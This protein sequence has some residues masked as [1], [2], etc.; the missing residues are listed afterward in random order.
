MV[1]RVGGVWGVARPVRES[2]LRAMPAAIPEPY[3]SRLAR[4]RARLA[5]RRLDG[6][7]ITDRN[8]QIWATG[9]TGEDGEVLITARRVVLLT[10]GRFDETADREAPWATKV[11]RTQRGPE[12][13]AKQIRTLKLRRVGIDPAR[14]SAARYHALAKLIRPAKLCDLEGFVAALRQC[15]DADELPR[16]RRAI[17]IAQRAFQRMRRWLR[18]GHSERQIAAKLVYE[19]QRLGASGPAFAPIVAVAG[20]ASQPHYEPGDARLERDQ[21]LLVDF[22]AR[23]D[24]YVSDLTRVIWIGSIRPAFQR[25]YDTVVAAHDAAVAAVRPGIRAADVDH[26][27]RETISQAGYG[28]YFTHA[29]GHGIGLDVHEAP[30]IGRGSRQTLEAGMVVTIEPGIYIPGRIGVRIESDVLVT[31]NGARVLSS[32]RY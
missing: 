27:A 15:K 2:C 25:V 10:D 24:G 5:K 13:T 21:P 3:Q 1:D 14:I 30:R 23:A 16:I 17:D 9:F 12:A 18:V 8:D 20:N 4:L 7:L 29:T 11:L 28:E 6:L 19:M 22:G 26:A 32:L 31:D